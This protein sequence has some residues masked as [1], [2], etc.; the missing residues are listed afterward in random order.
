MGTE[1]HFLVTYDVADPKRW[2]QVFKTMKGYG[3]WVQLSVFQCRLGAL[4]HRTLIHDLDMVVN[5]HE[6]HVLIFKLGPADAKK[7]DVTSLGKPFAPQ[8]KKPI[9]I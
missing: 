8:E 4:R 3:Q 1:H 9:I 7:L 5:K 2:R 6:D